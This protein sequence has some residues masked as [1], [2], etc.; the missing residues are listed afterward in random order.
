MKHGDER[1]HAPR[2]IR[3]CVQ[4]RGARGQVKGSTVEI[5]H[6]ARI[7]TAQLPFAQICDRRRAL[8]MLRYE[9]ISLP[10]EREA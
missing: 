4:C 7:I 1:A 8:N 3:R 10:H 6:H 5:R 9:G 2:Q